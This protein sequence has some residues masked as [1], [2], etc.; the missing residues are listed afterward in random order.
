MKEQF[1][2]WTPSIKTFL[3]L[4]DASGI[5]EEYHAAGFTM[6]IRQLYYQMVAR[7]LFPKEWERNGTTNNPHSYKKFVAILGKA[8]L[9]GLVDWEA[10]EDRN[11]EVSQL[12][13]W[14][15]P[16]DILLSAA[17]QFRLDK[18]DNQ[19]KYVELWC[20]KDALSNVLEPVARKWDVCY[21]ANK[22]YSSLSAMYEAARKRFED[23]LA[24]GKEVAIIYLGD[25][26]PS[27]IDMTRDVQDRMTL[28]L[29]D[30]F[31]SVFPFPVVRAAL[32]MDQIKTHHPPENFAKPTDSRFGNYYD[33]FGETSWELDALPPDVL[34][35]IAEREIE[36]L[37]DLDLFEEVV[38]KERAF[39][40]RLQQYAEEIE[41]GE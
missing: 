4:N 2:P 33:Q 37:V 20:E 5:V 32:N 7:D 31:D 23:R 3:V 28:F 12:A 13:H 14:E 36:K 25:H 27:G 1:V 40:S 19:P 10:I 16:K 41:N 26:D 38:S 21:M 8:R 24:A 29:G 18:W 17:R 6:T 30:Y 11:R 39:K 15:S 22:G 34:A 9:A 35:D